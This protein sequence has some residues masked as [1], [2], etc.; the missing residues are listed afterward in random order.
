M[1]NTIEPATALMCDRGRGQLA[2]MSSL[3]SFRGYSN[4]PA[5]CASKAAVRLYGEGLRGRLTGSG[6]D[7]NV[8]CPGFVRTPLTDGVPGM[9]F[10]VE[11][12][13]AVRLMA[14]AIEAR[15]KTF[16]FPWQMNLLKEVMVRAPEWLVRRL[17]PKPR[18]RSTL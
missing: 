8:V 15:R 7:V 16:T 5:Y 9:M 10:L 14:G 13:D 3:A 18:D 12:D 1:L 6:I 2:V 11:C 4:A 17:A